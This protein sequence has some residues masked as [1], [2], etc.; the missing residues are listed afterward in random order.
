MSEK[1]E[2]MAQLVQLIQ[3]HSAELME[4]FD[5]V[6]IFVTIH[7]GESETTAAY[8]YGMGNWYARSGQIREWTLC[9]D[10]LCRERVKRQER[11]T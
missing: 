5:S 4:H 6:H 2:Q 10:E 3:R 7:R 11:S 9:N 8:D 1:T